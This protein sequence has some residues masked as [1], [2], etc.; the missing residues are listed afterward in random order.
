MVLLDFDGER[1][2]IQT[3]TINKITVNKPNISSEGH[4]I[5]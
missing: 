4:V 1:G 5:H 3:E 2:E